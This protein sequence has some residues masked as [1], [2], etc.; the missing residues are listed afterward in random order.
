VTV[1]GQGRRSP[2]PACGEEDGD[3]GKKRNGQSP[4][5]AKEKTTAELL[6]RSPNERRGPRGLKTRAT[7]TLGLLLRHRLRF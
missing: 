3:G 2:G 4:D 7:L 6:T 5:D 1:R